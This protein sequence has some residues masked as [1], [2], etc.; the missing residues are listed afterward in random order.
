MEWSVRWKLVLKVA[1]NLVM[2]SVGQT[3][4]RLWS[5][6]NGLRLLPTS[7]VMLLP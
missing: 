1:F 3:P 2:D 5:W 4:L 6:T 7:A